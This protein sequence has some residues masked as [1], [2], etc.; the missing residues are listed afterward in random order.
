MEPDPEDERDTDHDVD[1]GDVLV[2]TQL[3]EPSE[4]DAPTREIL[5][6]AAPGPDPAPDPVEAQL[7]A[8]IAAGDE[9]SRLVY[10]DWLEQ[11]ARSIEAEFLRVGVALT[12]EA[13]TSPG[14]RA[15]SERLRGL[16][17]QVPPAWRQR[18]ARGPIENCAQFDFVCPQQWTAL[19]P[20]AASA[21]RH[22]RA[23]ARDVQLYA[24]VEDARVGAPPGAC[25]AIEDG[26]E[27]W[28]DDMLAGGRLC[29]DCYRWSP[30]RAAFCTDCGASLEPRAP[31]MVMGMIAPL[32]R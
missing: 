21:V 25:V 30:R 5:P 15:V 1:D 26:A 18:V 8:A 16:R 31:P 19:A 14:F 27:R 4:W 10:A 3:P 24:S 20:T 32:P 28:E 13:P 11:R 22:C 7:L 6:P 23:C 9:P 12:L 17:W 29:A 2:A